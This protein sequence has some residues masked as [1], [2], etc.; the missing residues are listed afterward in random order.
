M[1]K[2]RDQISAPSV[3]CLLACLLACLMLRFSILPVNPFSAFLC[4]ISTPFIHA[5]I[6]P[7]KRAERLLRTR[8]CISGSIQYFILYSWRLQGFCGLQCRPA[9]GSQCIPAGSILRRQKDPVVILKIPHHF[10]KEDIRNTGSYW[11]LLSAN[12]LPVTDAGFLGSS[13]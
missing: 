12:V 9:C 5:E 10:W 4:N 8:R 13:I 11:H 7:G 3:S 2:R 6:R 1:T